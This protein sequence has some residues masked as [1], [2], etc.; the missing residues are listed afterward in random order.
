MFRGQLKKLLMLCFLAAALSLTLEGRAQTP[1]KEQALEDR[2]GSNNSQLT[3]ILLSDQIVSAQWDTKQ[4]AGQDLI[5]LLLYRK[6]GDPLANIDSVFS[7]KDVGVKPLI[8][9]YLEALAQHRSN[10]IQV[11][12][13]D[14]GLTDKSAAVRYYA[15]LLLSALHLQ[16]GSV[17]AGIRF[18]E[19]SLTSLE[20]FQGNGLE[21]TLDEAKY[22]ALSLLSTAF[23]LDSN[24]EEAG[25]SLR[26]MLSIAR[27]AAIE[28]ARFSLLNNLSAAYE[29][30]GDFTTALIVAQKMEGLE[31]SSEYEKVLSDYTLGRLYIKNDKA[32]RGVPLLEA[33]LANG[34]NGRLKVGA[35]LALA[36]GYLILRQ[37]DKAE[38]M[39]ASLKLSLVDADTQKAAVFQAI[40]A[41]IAKAKGDYESALSFKAEELTMQSSRL[42]SALEKERR[43]ASL[44]ASVSRK[45]YEEK[46]KSYLAESQFQ[47]NIFWGSVSI[48][49]LLL[50]ALGILFLAYK[51]T[52]QHR[53]ELETANQLAMAGEETKA[54]FLAM[55]NH[56]IR[57][58]LNTIIPLS[59]HMQGEIKG[60]DR[61]HL[62]DLI[63]K[64]G[65]DLLEQ[66]ENIFTL[67][68]STTRTAEDYSK[69]DV[70][71]L[72]IELANRAFEKDTQDLKLVFKM[73]P[74]LNSGVMMNKKEVE[75]ILSNVISN[76][77]KFSKK[78][79]RVLVNAISTGSNRIIFLVEDH[80]IG[81]DMAKLE[82][83]TKPFEQVDKSIKRRFGGSGL[84]MTVAQRAA[85]AIG[86]SIEYDSEIGRGTVVK[87]LVPCMV[88]REETVTALAA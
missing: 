19:G 12:R 14:R 39:T 7:N 35:Q 55:I 52:I 79:G 10:G 70:R 85:R 60:S 86:A 31:K 49:L 82:D 45:V 21:I 8:L 83:F 41:D 47:K 30:K 61:K 78:N 76:A 48:I 68:N 77:V 80:G 20:G 33:L 25:K 54:R 23:I 22:N 3:A 1:L 71:A 5:D 11:D 50:S 2:K 64:A 88:T 58:P 87:I 29:L 36:R 66:V 57:T 37:L 26:D 16:R 69:C 15:H 13:L 18:A 81:F 46:E 75:I 27:T 65:R 62:I 67:S 28:V 34:I 56:E 73:S 53:S 6:V 40:L 24:V 84:G 4:S 32:K 59:E 74:G 51:R 9:A 38:S 44:S 43:D 17:L 63:A 42:K 72:L